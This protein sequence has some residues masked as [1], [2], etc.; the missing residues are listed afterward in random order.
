MAFDDRLA[1]APPPLF[2]SAGFPDEKF[3]VSSAQLLEIEEAVLSL[4]RAALAQGHR[5]VLHADPDVAPLVALTAAEYA[6]PP[7]TEGI[8][9]P[10]PRVTI[11]RTPDQD[12]RLAAALTG[13]RGV[14]LTSF[15]DVDVDNRGRSDRTAAAIKRFTPAAGIVLGGA[16]DSVLDFHALQQ[17]GIPVHVIGTAVVGPLLVELPFREY[18]AVAPA[19]REIEWGLGE[20]D[21]VPDAE[22]SVPY[23]YVMQRLI[24][25]LGESTV[26]L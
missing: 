20:P 4:A 24:S 13:L 11:L 1:H 14:E 7:R 15:G 2:I 3:D 26:E 10:A 16:D 12:D 6:E 8:L 22:R 25:Q 17:D 19:L 21:V 23:P 18:D 5:L 9:T